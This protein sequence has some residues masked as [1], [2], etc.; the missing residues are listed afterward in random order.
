MRTSASAVRV[1]SIALVAA[2]VALIS[3]GGGGDGSTLTPLETVPTTTVVSTTSAPSQS[4]APPTTTLDEDPLVIDALDG[5]R[6]GLIAI[7]ASGELRDPMTASSRLVG[8][9][10][11]FFISRDGLALTAYHPIGAASE[12]TVRHEGETVAARVI[13]VSEC[14]GVALLA[15]DVAEPVAHFRW[16]PT[17]AAVG[18]EIYAAGFPD[19]SGE[20]VLSRGRVQATDGAG[21][22][23]PA[24]LLTSTVVHDARVAF[25][26]A[27]GP[28]LTREGEVVGL[29]L[30]SLVAARDSMMGSTAIPAVAAR[31]LASVLGSGDLEAWGLN[32]WPWDA[33]TT[34]VTGLW[35]A[36]VAASSPADRLGVLPGDLIV[37]MD[38]L[39]VGRGGDVAA[40]CAISRGAGTRAIPIEILRLDTSEFL[41]GQLGGDSGLQLEF[42]FEEDLGDD[43]DD[44]GDPY[45][46]VVRL[47]DDAGLVA[48]DVPAAWNELATGTEA[49]DAFGPSSGALAAS[50]DL[51]SFLNAVGSATVSAV[52]GVIVTAVDQDA[53]TIEDLLGRLAPPQG[54]CATEDTYDYDDG[55]F[56]G[57]Y[58]LWSDCGD[59]TTILVRLVARPTGPGAPIREEPW[60]VTVTVAAVTTADLDALDTVW[61]TFELLA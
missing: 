50:S 46:D 11:G 7:T 56:M 19:G 60:T 47:V 23:F 57:S 27:G 20:V 49:L 17:P 4:T 18:T 45:E 28:L 5:V 22:R 31:D 3:C 12:L 53:D 2:V 24:A 6:S 35:V 34:G 8:A 38:G 61:A 42:S 13:G 14:D 26:S 16:S 41:R 39:D 36:G 37:T 59:S 48:V 25:G 32:L 51:D 40:A 52:P 30:P 55:V 54:T 15:V 1:R 44:S 58:R 9:A 43:L 21:T 33:M 10:T 29:N